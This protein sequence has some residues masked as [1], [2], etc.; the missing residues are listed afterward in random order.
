MFMHTIHK[1]KEKLQELIKQSKKN[2]SGA[3]AF[4]LFDSYGFPF[5]LTKEIAQ[6]QGLLVD[7]Q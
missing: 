1:G 4:L 7:E 2:L 5:E 6:E 3:D